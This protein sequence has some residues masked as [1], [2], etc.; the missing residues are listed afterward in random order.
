MFLYIVFRVVVMYVGA[1]DVAGLELGCAFLCLL[2]VM[3]KGDEE[4]WESSTM[5]Y[6][7]V[8][9]RSC[10]TTLSKSTT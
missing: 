4:H 5:R 10:S 1:D 3:L 6:D 7:V 9:G 8:H 2:V